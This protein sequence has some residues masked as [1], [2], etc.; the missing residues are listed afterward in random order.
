[1]SGSVPAIIGE[2]A[3]NWL[4]GKSKRHGFGSGAA[5]VPPFLFTRARARDG[6]CELSEL[7]DWNE[8]AHGRAI[9]PREICSR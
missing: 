7:S 3:A 1:M 4:P 6:A 2:H 5:T 9:I 8:C